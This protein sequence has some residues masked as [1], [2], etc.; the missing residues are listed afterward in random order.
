MRGLVKKIP[1]SQSD[2]LSIT[3]RMQVNEKLYMYLLEKRANTYIA[4]SGIVPQTKVI[5]KARIGG[6]VSKNKDSVLMMFVIIGFVLAGVFALL[7]YLLYHT[8]EN[9]K[10]LAEYNDSFIR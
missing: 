5:E 3:R 2:M 9:S 6:L 10:E 1:K 8:F 7:K 4:K